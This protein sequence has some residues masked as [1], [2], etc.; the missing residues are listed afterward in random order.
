A[1]PVVD[2][3]FASSGIEPEIVADAELL[4]LLPGLRLPVAAIGHLIALKLLSRNDASRPQDLVDLR[5][6]VGRVTDAERARARRAVAMIR[7]RG[8]HR[9]RDL[10]TALD[11]FL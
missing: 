4:E 8:F 3:L 7:A 6:L 1:G 11:E 10:E 5:A 2:L 9:G